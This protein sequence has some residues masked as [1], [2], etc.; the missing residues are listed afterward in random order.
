[1]WK[2]RRNPK[3]PDDKGTS[4]PRYSLFLSFD[5][6]MQLIVDRLRE[7]LSADSI[8]LKTVVD[9]IARNRM[10]REWTVRIQSGHAIEADAICLAIPSYHAATL[11]TNID[12]VLARELESIRYASTATINLAFGRTSIAHPLNGF[13]FVVPQIERKSL[14]ACSFSSVKF[15]NRAP[16]DCVLLRAFVGGDLQPE[17]FAL[18]DD[19][20]LARVLGDLGELLRINGAPLFSL[21]E[22]WPRSMAQYHIGHLNKIESIKRRLDA[23]ETLRLAGNAYDGAGLPDCVRSGETAAENILSATDCSEGGVIRK[24]CTQPIST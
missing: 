21:I 11:L 8:R 14:I 5:S 4:G 13:G 24:G 17:M 3:T 7:R 23:F 12:G 6:G 2:E 10:G 15:A 19:E 22:R 18:D 9:S 20:M 16:D 1:M